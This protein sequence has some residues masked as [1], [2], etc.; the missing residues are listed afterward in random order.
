MA[1]AIHI[2]WYFSLILSLILPYYYAF[3]YISHST[4]SLSFSSRRVYRLCAPSISFLINIMIL[5]LLHST[6][7]GRHDSWV[8][9]YRFLG[10]FPCHTASLYLYRFLIS[11]FICCRY[12][13]SILHLPPRISS[14]CQFIENT[15]EAPFGC[16]AI[17]SIFSCFSTHLT[18]RRYFDIF[19][20][21]FSLFSHWFRTFHH[22]MFLFLTHLLSYMPLKL[23][24]RHK[25]CHLYANFKSSTFHDDISLGLWYCSLAVITI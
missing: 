24:S 13:T 1:N 3:I 20:H 12:H 14:I 17:I 21:T 4:Y 15:E 9:S 11:C 19:S 6:A 23:L 18:S 2:R 8:S 25:Y 22:D 5:A 10:R 7:A 16:S